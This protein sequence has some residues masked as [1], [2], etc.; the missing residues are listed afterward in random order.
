MSKC[1]GAFVYLFDMNP[2]HD[3]SPCNTASLYSL[4]SSYKLSELYSSWPLTPL[5]IDVYR[6]LLLCGRLVLHKWDSQQMA[7]LGGQCCEGAEVVTINVH[8]KMAIHTNRITSPSLWPGPIM[9]LSLSPVHQPNSFLNTL[10]NACTTTN[11]SRAYRKGVG[12]WV[13]W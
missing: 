9:A 4:F 10:A 6:G 5:P 11:L 13:R 7:G 2:S 12:E 1:K 3:D 8:F